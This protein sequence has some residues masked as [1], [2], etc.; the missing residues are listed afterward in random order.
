MNSAY[1]FDLYI[2]GKVLLLKGTFS[3]SL[4][5]PLYTVVTILIILDENILKSANIQSM[6][7]PSLLWS[8]GSWIH[9]YLCNQCLSPLTL[10]VRIL[11]RR[12]KLDTTLYDKVCQWFSPGT[13]VS[14]TNNWL[15]RYNWNIVESGVKH[16]NPL[17]QSTNLVILDLPWFWVSYSFLDPLCY[18]FTIT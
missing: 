16:N 1:N 14:S 12:G 3:G 18:D 9:N 2:K 11:L 15:P 7:V 5:Y 17:P 4:E 13:P 10:R 6:K 8:Y